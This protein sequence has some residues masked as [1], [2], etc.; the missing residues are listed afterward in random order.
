MLLFAIQGP[1][2]DPACD[3]AAPAIVPFI[4][5]Q[6]PKCTGAG[7]AGSGPAGCATLMLNHNPGKDTSGINPPG[8]FQNDV[9]A[10]CAVIGRF[11]VVQY[12]I[13]PLPP[14]D[15]PSLERRD[16][17][18]GA[19][20]VPV[21]GNIE[22]LQVQYAQGFTN[23]FRDEPH[24]PVSGD[25]ATWVSQVR[26]TVS[27]RGASTDLEGVVTGTFD[28]GARLRRVFTTT[29]SLRNQLYHAT[30]FVMDE[31]WNAWN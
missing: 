24:L 28:D 4:V 7:G 12:R 3:D 15:D 10:D 29:V 18:L 21:A 2:G 30:E 20:W 17:A 11:H 6:P 13:Y 5:T 8:G 19:D 31:T 25:P 14:A 23:D 16:L 1:N 27:G 26:V 9:S 22:N